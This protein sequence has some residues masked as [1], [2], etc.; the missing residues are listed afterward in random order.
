MIH[1]PLLRRA[2]TI[3]VL[4]LGVLLMTGLFPILVVLALLVDAVVWL[5]DRKPAMSTRLVVFGWLY[6][7]GEV[8]AVSAAGLA[9]LFRQRRS[10]ELTYRLQD[11]WTG[12]NLYALRFVFSLDFRVEGSGAP[13]P[14]PIVVLARHA[15]LIDSLLPANLIARE[16]GFRLRY[17]LKRELLADPALD[18]AGNRLPNYFVDRS[19]RESDAEL[20]RIRALGLDLSGSEG[21]VIF[22]EGTR[23]SVEKRDRAKRR[24]EARS[25]PMAALASSYQN[26]LPPRPAGTLAL[27]DSTSCDIVVLAHRGLEGFATVSDI[28]SGRLIGTTITA[29]MWR[30]ERARI[31]EGRN[32]RVDWLFGLWA[33]VDQWVTSSESAITN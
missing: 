14:G 15:S 3:S 29:R 12:W 25:G 6:L 4:V 7:L 17:V 33:E 1:Q 32:E 26:V 22:P 16:H 27:L 10:T 19:S 2:I 9:G 20:E 5:F 8:V 11:L 21:V 13:T 23:F 31:P 18:I 24:Y 30:V 28:W